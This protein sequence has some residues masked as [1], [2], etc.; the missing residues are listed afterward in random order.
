MTIVIR[1]AAGQISAQSVEFGSESEL[2]EILASRP[3]LLVSP[4]DDALALIGRQVDLPDAGLLDLLYVSEA[5]LPVAVEVKL[6]RNGESRRQ[7]VAQIIDYLSALTSLTVDELDVQVDGS[8][9]EALH[10]FDEQS[11][12]G[13]GFERRWQ[14]VGANL[15]AGLAR[16]VLVLDSMPPDL[17]RIG[18]FLSEHTNLD[19][20]LVT[21][22]KHQ[23]P[24]IGSVFVPHVAIISEGEP[25]PRRSDGPKLI[26]Q[27]LAAVVTAYDQIAPADL[28]THGTADRYRKIRPPEWPAGMNLHYEFIQARGVIGVELHLENASAAR[29]AADLARLAGTR[30]GPSQIQLEWDPTWS[31]RRGRLTA[32]YQLGDD[33]QVIAQTMLDLIRL[34]RS[35]VVDIA[36]HLGGQPQSNQRMEP[37]RAGS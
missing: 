23:A 37:T 33:P 22:N 24:E 31:S 32:R 27:E 29:L 28:R 19:I 12:A 7:I 8:L 18:R 14:S 17:E 36:S 5:G 4:G 20:R 1:T 26:R 13:A 15:R 10:S 2:E 25:A 21:I 30:L 16:V 35:T 9:E 11:T 6:A 34:T 3:E